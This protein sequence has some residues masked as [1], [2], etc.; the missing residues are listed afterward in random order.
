MAAPLG[1]SSASHCDR[2][3]SGVASPETKKDCAESNDSLEQSTTTT[4]ELLLQEIQRR[5]STVVQIHGSVAE[6]PE[7]LLDIIKQLR[8]LSGIFDQYF[9][10]A[11]KKLQSGEHTVADT[12]IFCSTLLQQC[13]IIPGVRFYPLLEHDEQTAH[14]VA[15]MEARRLIRA[16]VRK[17]S[18]GRNRSKHLTTQKEKNVSDSKVDCGRGQKRHRRHTGVV[19]EHQDESESDRDA[20]LDESSSSECDYVSAILGSDAMRVVVETYA[21]KLRFR[22]MTGRLR[23]KMASAC[24]AA[25]NRH[26]GNYAGKLRFR[27]MTGRL[28]EKMASACRAA[29]NRHDGDDKEHDKLDEFELGRHAAP[30]N[31][32]PTFLDPMCSF[33]VHEVD[34]WIEDESDDVNGP[35]QSIC[36][37]DESYYPHGNKRN[38]NQKEATVDKS[39]AAPTFKYPGSRAP[40]AST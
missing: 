6:K 18:H 29:Q 12:W 39:W 35:V 30:T 1:S 2:Y 34:D 24:R 40:V 11:F 7:E 32:E 4:D 38:G 15:L 16:R 37:H 23:E 19:K 28:R 9:D 8:R 20:W 13:G 3:H 17:R 10:D 27:E 31:K 26:G 25:Q 14:D 33:I 21:G 36:V 5:R 22:E